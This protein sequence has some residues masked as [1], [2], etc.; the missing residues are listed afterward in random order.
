[1]CGDWGD[2]F[3]GDFHDLVVTTVNSHE[4]F[5]EPSTRQ[6]PSCPDTSID[7]SPVPWCRRIQ[8]S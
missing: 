3:R 6:T 8:L 2:G 7:T 4:F 5:V 1:M